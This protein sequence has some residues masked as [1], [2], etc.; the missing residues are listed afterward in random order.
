MLNGALKLFDGRLTQMSECLQECV[1]SGIG[2]MMP[3]VCFMSI[4][5]GRFG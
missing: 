4:T 3:L 5:R 2:A 1:I